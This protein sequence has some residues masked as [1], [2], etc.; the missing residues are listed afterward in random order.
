MS[1]IQGQDRGQDRRRIVFPGK[2]RVFSYEETVVGMDLSEGG[3]RIRTKRPINIRTKVI[4]E[5][6]LPSKDKDGE[7]VPAH[8]IQT[9][10]RWS[11]QS[12]DKTYYSLGLQFQ[13]RPAPA[14][15]VYSLLETSDKE[16]EGQTL[17]THSTSLLGREVTC[18]A[19]GQEKVPQ[20]SLRSRSMQ[21][22]TNIFGTPDYVRAIGS[23]DPIDYNILLVTVCP[24]CGFGAPGEEFFKLRPEDEVPF[25]VQLFSPHWQANLE[26][27]KAKLAQQTED[28]WGEDRTVEQAV[29][30]YELAQ[31]TFEA[32]CQHFPK[33]GAFVRWLANIR[34]THAQL[35]MTYLRDLRGGARDRAIKL[36]ESASVAMVQNFEI[37]TEFQ[38][39]KA[40][41]LIC[42]AS[43]YLGDDETLEK[44]MEYLENFGKTQA[45]EPESEMAKALQQA[46]ARVKALYQERSQYHKDKMN[47][48]FPQ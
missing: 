48:F 4:L 39:L 31:E 37:L 19:C 27:R 34:L 21:I 45:P 9:V 16:A 26:H 17:R 10:V 28:F 30:S 44:F 23:R 1:E 43:I 33:N 24:Q 7:F 35:L 8:P 40:A 29:V 2:I 12:N 20:Y 38:S 25:D 3:C 18:Y 5:I 14:Q 22:R 32:L 47:T 15:G 11:K 46:R 42:T 13:N 6:F 41:Q 36:V